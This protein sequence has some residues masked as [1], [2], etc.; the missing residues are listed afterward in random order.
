MGVEFTKENVLKYVKYMVG[1]EQLYRE[2]SRMNVPKEKSTIIPEAV[3][4][5][6]RLNKENG[7]DF[8]TAFL[9]NPE[10]VTSEIDEWIL[11][12]QEEFI[13][14]WLEDDTKLKV[15][16]F[17]VKETI[18]GQYLMRDEELKIRVKWEHCFSGEPDYFTANEIRKIEP[19]F[20]RFKVKRD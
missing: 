3:K 9:I 5:W 16:L 15:P 18:T 8:A 7:E 17:Y 14:A 6:I 4:K 1:K 20:L 2:I 19:D 12:N 13:K 10:K 11:K